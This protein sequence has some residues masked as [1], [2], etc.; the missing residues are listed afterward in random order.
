MNKNKCKKENLMENPL[1]IF[2]KIFNEGKSLIRLGDGEFKQIDNEHLNIGYFRNREKNRECYKDILSNDKQNKILVAVQPS[3]FGLKTDCNIYREKFADGKWL[4]TR[5]EDKRYHKYTINTVNY[6]FNKNNKNYVNFLTF[7]SDFFL[8]NIRIKMLDVFAKGIKKKDIVLIIGKFCYNKY[9]E[10]T[11]TTFKNCKNLYIY[12]TPDKHADKFENEMCKKI[13]SHDFNNSIFV[14]ACG[15]VFKYIIYHY[16]LKH[17]NFQ[18]IDMGRSLKGG[19][20]KYGN[21]T[22]EY[23]EKTYVNNPEIFEYFL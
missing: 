23:M 7:F 11:I 4:N 21:G 2:Q 6:Y 19:F 10:E 1:D 12:Y 17:N 3:I 5:G 20:C 16:S 13:E 8:E 22:G 18:G 15:P 9:R 14:G